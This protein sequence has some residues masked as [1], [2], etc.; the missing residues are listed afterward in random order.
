MQRIAKLL[1]LSVALVGCS[2]S[3]PEKPAQSQQIISTQNIPS[4]M[5]G[6]E[7]KQLFG[8]KAQGSRQG[9]EPFGSYAKGCMAGGVALAETEPTWQ[10]MRLSRNRNWGHPEV[11][12]FIQD[13]SRVAA[14]QP[15]WKGLY[16][17]DIS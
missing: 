4:S 12:D 16:V 2:G 5:L 17:G 13:L 11:V 1:I 15:G 6:V 9:A 3:T 10:A 7:A 8:A 14:S